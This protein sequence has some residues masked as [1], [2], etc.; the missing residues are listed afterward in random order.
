MNAEI[1]VQ[2]RPRC[3]PAEP[4]DGEFLRRLFV[5]SRPELAALP[6]PLRSQV[7]ELQVAAQRRQYRTAHPESLE[8]VVEV[9]GTPVGRCWVMRAADTYRVLDI[10]ISSAHRRRGL[11]SLLLRDLHAEAAQ[12]GVPLELSVWGANLDAVRLYR[13][14]GFEQVDEANGYLDLRWSAGTT[15]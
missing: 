3:R 12:A 10:A 11:G 13:R 6:D 14:L 15:G 1:P 7:V 8:A 9:D 4:H 5:E 2:G